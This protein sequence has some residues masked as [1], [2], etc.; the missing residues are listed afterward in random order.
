MGREQRWAASG[1]VVLL[2]AIWGAV[3]ARTVSEPYRWDPRSD[4]NTGLIVFVIGVAILAFTALWLV[5]GLITVRRVAAGE[6]A[7]RPV[8]SLA[9]VAAVLSAL[10]AVATWS[11]EDELLTAL[12]GFQALALLAWSVL[13][14]TPRSVAH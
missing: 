10:T 3:G 13:L 1:V 2:G 5:A 7:W 9:G 6:W 11:V 14:W 8:A 12:F 4:D